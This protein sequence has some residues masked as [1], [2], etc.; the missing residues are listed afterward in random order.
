M[1][2]IKHDGTYD[3]S[4]WVSYEPSAANYHKKIPIVCPIHGVFEQ[5]LANHLRGSKC[6]SCKHITIAS[7]NRK[8]KQ[9]YINKAT[10]IHDN[11]Y[12]YSLWEEVLNTSTDLVKIIC[13]THGI[14]QQTP[15]SHIDKKAG[16]PRCKCENT[17][18]TN[19]SNIG[20]NHHT[21]SHISDEALIKLLNKNWLITEH[22]GSKRTLED[23]ALELGV[24]DTTVGRYCKQH[25]I[26]VQRFAV[27]AGE[28]NLQDW[29]TSLGIPLVSNDR[30]IIPPQELD[31]Y[32][33]D[34]NL[35]IEYC[36]LYWHSDV[37][38][39]INY[40]RN[41]YRLCCD[42][43]IRLITLF[44]DEW[45]SN[46]ELVKQK[47]LSIL[48]KDT[49]ERVFARKCT[50]IPVTTE[51][52]Q[53]FFNQNHIQGSG[54]G[55]INIGLDYNNEL[56]ACMSFIQNKNG[57][58][59]LNR[60]ATSKQIIGG[61]SKLLSHFKKTHKWTQII[62]FA[63]LRWSQGNVYEKNRFVID[64][65]LAPDYSYSP[66]GHRRFH[67]F[68]YRRKYLSKRLHHYNSQLSE[69]SN[70]D[71]NGLLRIWDCGKIR[72]IINYC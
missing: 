63:D 8:G 28:R 23:I 41:K 32:L 34:Y 46:N 35:A 39:D 40:H 52:K 31:I 65:I 69:R 61:F 12:D 67:K 36:G 10:Q 56:V 37:H 33:P 17:R 13:K 59:V 7:K 58:F 26:A 20:R 48:G 71:N 54:P 16:C 70:C 66:D 38:K 50:I 68:N 5:S 47:L 64:K 43:N 27:S 45:K 55:S 62:S 30:S 18:H 53:L 19:L 22:V 42:K 9:F 4:L 29:I 6:P 3:Y 2:S 1:A 72:Y 14:F 21:Q 49:R 51:Q 15:A 44:E 25:G 11:R 60:Y 24:Q 57:I